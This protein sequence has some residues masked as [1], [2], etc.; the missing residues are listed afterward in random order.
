M[1]ISRSTL[2][3]STRI[4]GSSIRG[5]PITSR[6]CSSGELFHFTTCYNL[7]FLEAHRAS[8]P[9][10]FYLNEE[11]VEVLIGEILFESFGEE[12]H[13]DKEYFI[14]GDKYER[15]TIID[16]RRDAAVTAKKRAMIVFKIR[17]VESNDEVD[18]YTVKIPKTKAAVFQIVHSYVVCGTAFRLIANLIG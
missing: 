8:V 10:L 13:D 14:E 2:L 11:I 17:S 4:S 15:R 6:T 18:V 5:C 1:T 3:G 7:T 9:L 16:K 12:D